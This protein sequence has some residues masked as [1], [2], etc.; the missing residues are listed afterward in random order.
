MDCISYA[1]QQT[2]LCLKYPLCSVYRY[3]AVE[4]VSIL[5][6]SLKKIIEKIEK[7]DEEDEM[8]E[9]LQRLTSNYSREGLETLVQQI[10][11][12]KFFLL[13][14]HTLLHMK[15]VPLFF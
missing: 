7:V 12:L 14:K 3:E 4:Y 11:D 2:L 5:D 9:Q 15:H 10:T 8:K 13:N 6:E 1:F